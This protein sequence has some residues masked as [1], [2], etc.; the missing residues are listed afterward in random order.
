MK[1]NAVMKIE[2]GAPCDER[3]HVALSQT[4]RV[5]QGLRFWRTSQSGELG[6]P[7]PLRESLWDIPVQ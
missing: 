2:G 6:L 1:R 5:V 3:A 4:Q 7:Y